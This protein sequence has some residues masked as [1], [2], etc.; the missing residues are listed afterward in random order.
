MAP[1]DQTR[2]WLIIPVEVQVRELTARL[3]I[4]AIAASRGFD[5][6]IGHDRVVR[7]LAA[8]LTSGILF[9]KSLGAKGDR[10]IRRYARLGY[11]LTA[12]DEESTGFY[13]NPELYMNTRLSSETLEKAEKWFCI[14][15]TLREEAARRYPQFAD[16]FETSGLPRTDTWREQ[17]HGLFAADRRRIETE[18]GKFIL[19]CSNFGS[20]IHARAGKFVENQ[21]AKQDKAHAAASEYRE[22]V[23]E[24][25]RQNLEAFVAMLPSLREW[26]PDHKVII[27]PHPSEDRRFWHRSVAGLDGYVVADDGLATPWI[28]ASQCL[29]HHGCTTGIEA[30][31]LGKPHVMYAPFRD[32]HH[33]TDVMQ[34]FAPIVHDSKALRSTLEDILVQGKSYAKS[35]KSLEKW[36]AS[37]TG[38]LVSEG[39]IGSLEAIATGSSRNLPSWLP[40]LRYGPRHLVAEYWPQ[41]EARRA[42]SKQKWQGTSLAE[43]SQ[44][45]AIISRSASFRSEPKASEV[46][47]QLYHISTD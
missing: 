2:G 11:K 34:D 44:M 47:P 5:V 15:D 21:F 9:D 28:L 6:L 24:Q 29:V 30:E 45:L 23:L 26:F 16:R 33:D 8:Y 18:H 39:I 25:G 37:L 36:Y 42:Y 17:F 4:A 12:L 27:R 40:L 13:P 41:A 22:R 20:I 19:F 1:S 32:D 10:K 35:R 38:P 3:L 7:R 14:S 31:L 43:I 46:F